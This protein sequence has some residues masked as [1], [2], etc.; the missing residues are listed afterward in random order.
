MAMP[1]TDNA[2]WLVP[3]APGP[4][5]A[6]VRLPGSKSMTNRALIL[7]ALAE[8]ATP[9]RRPLI[10]RDTQ[11]MATALR[12]LGTRIDEAGD[13]GWLITPAQEAAC[14]GHAEI[15]VGN[16]GTVLRFLPALA[17][18]SKADVTFRGDRRVSQRPVG[19]L[20]AALRHLGARIT[21]QGDGAVP[22][23]VHGTGSVRGGTVTLD[24]SS[25]SQ[26]I[27]GLLLAAPR[28]GSGAFIRHEGPALPSAPH[29][30][31]SVRM[32]RAAGC[33]V[34][35]GAEA[36]A[37]PGEDAPQASAAPR[38]AQKRQESGADTVHHAWRVFP[39]PISPGEIVIEPDLSNA[40][41]FLAAALA[42]GGE[43]TIA[44]WP[45]DS[46]QPA[47]RIIDVLTAMG[48]RVMHT[49]AGLRVSGSGQISG[50]G[51]DL[52]AVGELAPVLTALAALADSPSEFTG[53]GHLR[54]HESDRLAALAG[55]IGKLG[56]EVTELADGL[57][58]KPRPLHADGVVFDS[59][60]DHRLV[61]AAAVLGL[62]TGGLRVR[63]AVTVG[64][65]FP[66]FPAYWARTLAPAG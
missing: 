56:G 47:A 26:L 29:I 48:A 38:P 5:S 59:H 15:D 27:S 21:D 41:P 40:V 58:I 50:I 24:A 43:V 36:L 23:V 12:T 34:R 31:M 22:F 61:M 14:A 37:R 6:L 64:K 13:D 63:N 44:D 42:T 18:L 62:V 10:A 45:D 7:A 30:E 53:I 46:L 57:A 49:P 16:A 19:P 4:V 20:L 9:I 51:A 55:E 3:R 2:D 28:F 35:A 33:E 60:D 11:L 17:A 39:G 52:S 65:T 32:L 1:G 66:G 8:S 25:S 54:R